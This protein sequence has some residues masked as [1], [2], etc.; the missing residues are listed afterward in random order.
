MIYT[1]ANLVVGYH[2]NSKAQRHFMDDSL[3]LGT[4]DRLIV[5]QGFALTFSKQVSQLKS[6]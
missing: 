3:N 4:L 5:V 1:Q 2:A 6:D